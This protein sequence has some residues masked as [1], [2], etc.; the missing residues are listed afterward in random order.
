MNI[1]PFVYSKLA[2][3]FEF[4]KSVRKNTAIDNIITE[5]IQRKYLLQ[6]NQ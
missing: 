5:I 2:L 4:A 1:M 6:L 3:D